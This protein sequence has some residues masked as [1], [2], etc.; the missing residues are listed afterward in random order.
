MEADN[1]KTIK[2]LLLEALRLD[3][4]ARAA[5]LD[6]AVITA[7]AR[8]EVESLLALE[9]EARDFM[10]LPAGEFSADIFASAED[11]VLIKQRIGAY[12]IVSELGC[13]G[14]G[15]VYLARRA[16]G[17]FEQ[18][19][20]VKMLRRE[21]NTDRLR[22]TFAREKDILAALSHPNIARLL[23]AGSTGDGIPYL[24]MEYVRGEPLDKFCHRRRLSL[25]ARL[26]L[27]GK[28]C[29]AVAYAHR[30]LVVHRDIKPGNILVNE[31]GEPKLLDFGISKLLGAGSA[32]AAGVTQ[33]G[34]LT[35]LYASPE[36]VRGEPVTTASDVYS[37]GV[38]L[39]KVLTE[40]LPYRA[41]EK[42]N[43][44]LLREITESAP[45]LPSAAAQ[46]PVTTSQLKGDLDNIILKSLSKEPARRYQTVEEF[47]ADLRRFAEGLPVL[48]RPATL[49]YRAAKFY[50]RNKV[51]VWAVALILIS[52]C[53]GLVAALWQARAA[54]VQARIASEAR[55]A[56]ELETVRVREQK[57]R[58]EKTSRFMQSFLNYANPHW[59]GLG[60]RDEGRTD[61]TVREAL[62]DVVTRMDTELAD[63]PEVRADL[64]YTIGE[65]YAGSG[66]AERAFQHLRQSL[67]LYRQVHGDEHPK[68][69]RG[70]YYLMFYETDLQKAEAQLRQGI[71]IMRRTDPENVNLPYMLQTLGEWIVKAERE[72][73]DVTRL[74]EAESLI[75]EAKTLFTRQKGESHGATVSTDN[76]LV[77]LA[78]VRGDLAEAESISKEVLRR[79]QQTSPGSYEHI[80]ALVYV[81][82]VKLRQGKAAEAEAFFRQALELARRRW[83][84]NDH[85]LV[86]L[87]NYVNQ[88]RATVAK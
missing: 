34:A 49:S 67:D 12:E 69:A 66:D 7:E 57:E 72:R 30:N 31:N 10:S 51:S 53:A 16:D 47:S 19:V 62:Q 61:F 65:V 39:F 27:F 14:M 81:G 44:D 24:V 11:D 25:D 9:A 70:M 80:S 56:A 20:A 2:G 22:R 38:V 17:K 26:T 37:L 84:A 41:A 85:R 18:T 42:T 59:S 71:S 40:E 73:R 54:R 32:D 4:Q 55:A 75:L 28:V 52:L 86:A 45:R 8:A 88:A 3:P 21:F 50:G 46:A 78:L 6:H 43:G 83:S 58:I 15:A 74:A 23:D 5:W 82:E 60:S 63:S 13:G 35:P 77:R 48:A 64:H 1:W 33:L 76:S 29:E 68:V 36:Q 79:F 87:V